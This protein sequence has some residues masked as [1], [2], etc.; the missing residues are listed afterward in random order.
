MKKLFILFAFLSLSFTVFSQVFVG[1][2]GKLHSSLTGGAI[3]NLNEVSFNTDTTTFKQGWAKIGVVVYYYDGFW[4][5]VTFSTAGVVVSN[6]SG[7]LSSTLS[8][9]LSSITTTS[10]FPFRA[11]NDNVTLEYWN[12]S[13]NTRTGTFSANASGLIS[14]SA[15]NATGI[16]FSG[17][18]V[19]V[20]NQ[21]LRISGGKAIVGNTIDAG[22]GALQVTGDASI[23]GNL[24]VA[25][26]GNFPQLNVINT[27]A[28]TAGGDAGQYALVA[29]ANKNLSYGNNSGQMFIIAND[30]TVSANYGGSLG[31]GAT[32]L[33]GTSNIAIQ[34]AIKSGRDDGISG[35][36][37]G[38]LAF[39]TRGSGANIIEKA[40]ISSSGNF[41]IGQ[42]A[43]YSNGKL[44]VTGNGFF[45]SSL[46]ASQFVDINNTDFQVTPSASSS[47]NNVTIASLTTTGLVKY[48]VSTLSSNAALTS[49]NNNITGGTSYSLPDATTNTGAEVSVINST[50]GSITITTVSSQV[51]GN[52]TTNSTYTILSEGANT[53]V[54]NGT[55]WLLK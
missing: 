55:K 10:P 40:R 31:L 13:N 22:T 45:T 11:Q 6:S 43:D 28:F 2:D 29:G 44:Q 19:T 9:I 16:N 17:A 50:S 18:P 24:N 7:V 48:Q 20:L 21:N 42:N 49:A 47:L 37:G 15:E 8:P 27:G 52:Y 51:I 30:P 46:T 14:L 1:G 53:F 35:N 3:S 54:S 5:P 39:Y 4:K 34:A 36:V 38:Y 33:T 41:L 23:S 26:I 25:G 32:Y 12:S